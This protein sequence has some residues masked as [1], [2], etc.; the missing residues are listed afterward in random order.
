MTLISCNSNT[1]ST[2]LEQDAYT[3][4]KVV[5][6]MKNVMSK[7]ELGSRIN[8]ETIAIKKGLYG[9]GPESYLTGE[10][11]INNGEAYVSK[12][13]TDSTMTLDKTFNTTAPFFVYGNVDTWKEIDLP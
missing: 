11:L 2:D 8:L 7:G 13:L 1:K 9:I 3:P 6:A 12:I 5:G 10:I 4:I